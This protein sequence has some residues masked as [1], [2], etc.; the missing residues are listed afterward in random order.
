MLIA[1]V[2]SLGASQKTALDTP[3]SAL[4]AVSAPRNVAEVW[5]TR[6]GFENRLSSRL[7]LANDSRALAAQQ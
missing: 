5:K 7:T 2:D 4:R 3:V 1:P 6:G